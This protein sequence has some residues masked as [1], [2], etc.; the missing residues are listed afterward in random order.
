MYDLKNKEIKMITF[1]KTLSI[2]LIL[3]PAHLISIDYSGFETDDT[4]NHGLRLNQ[5]FYSVE[6]TRDGKLSEADGEGWD[7]Y[8]HLDADKDGFVDYDEFASAEIPYPK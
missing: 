6:K 7:K 5:A 2:V 8:K 1:F 3:F 4:Y